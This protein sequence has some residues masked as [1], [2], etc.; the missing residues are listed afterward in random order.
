MVWSGH[1]VWGSV[2]R[3]PVTCPCCYS[4]SSRSWVR[5]VASGPRVYPA[6]HTAI[7]KN[8]WLCPHVWDWGFQ[9]Q[10]G[11]P[12]CAVLILDA[13]TERA[14]FL[15]L[16]RTSGRPPWPGSSTSFLLPSAPHPAGAVLVLFPARPN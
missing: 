6:T 1:L 7:T 4:G 2:S 10:S 15:A 13:D 8:S 9:Q 12:A 11:W 14:M 3:L 16:A 5:H